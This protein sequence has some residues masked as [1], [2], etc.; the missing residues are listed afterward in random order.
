MEASDI[1]KNL[2]L[3]LTILFLSPALF[4]QSI[5]EGRSISAYSGYTLQSSKLSGTGFNSELPGKGSLLYGFDFSYQ[6]QQNPTRYIF[7]YSTANGE[8]SAPSG[9]SPSKL[10]VQREEYSFQASLALWDSGILENLRLGLGYAYLQSGATDTSPNNVLT[11]QTTQGVLFG[12]SYTSKF[13]SDLSLISDFLIYLPHQFNESSQ[14]TGYN[15]RYIGTE[16]KF[17]AEYLFAD[18]AA[19]FGGMIYRLDQASFDGSVNR[20]VTGGVDAR[21]VFTIPIGLKF[22]Y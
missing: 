10:T 1:M 4:A 17:V 20:G 11:K 9:L 14:V 8:Q 22:G 13:S 21:T 15:T 5:E 19:V 16:I 3:T 6:G 2:R 7:K 18:N 12:L